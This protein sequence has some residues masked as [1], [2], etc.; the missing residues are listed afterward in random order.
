MKTSGSNDSLHS[1]NSAAS[2]TR[3]TRPIAYS[4]GNFRPEL[5]EELVIRPY[6]PPVQFKKTRILNKLLLFVMHIF[7]ISVFEMTFF[8]T[9]V[10]KYENQSLI[11]LIDAYLNKVIKTCNILTPP[12]KQDVSEIVDIFINETEIIQE[13]E[14][15]NNYRIEYNNNLLL[16]G[17]IYCITLFVLNIVIISV[18][19]LY[20]KRKIEYKTIILDNVIMVVCLGLYEY[21]FFTTIAFKYKTI[22]NYE[23]DTYII[24]KLRD[25]GIT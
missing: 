3:R 25:C 1:I 22:T 8:F 14:I 21:M 13:G 16:L 24:T 17:F 12:E 18:N 15:A 11:N 7:L 4:E 19:A 9:Y 2:P 6:T 20:F 10:T 23:L 5:V